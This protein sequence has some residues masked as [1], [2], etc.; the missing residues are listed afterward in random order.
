MAAVLIVGPRLTA[1]LRYIYITRSTRVIQIDLEIKLIISFPLL[2]CWGNQE[3]LFL[4]ACF[5]ADK[6]INLVNINDVKCVEFF[7]SE[8]I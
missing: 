7:I 8:V 3:N 4:K 2:Y 5:K 1:D 6:S